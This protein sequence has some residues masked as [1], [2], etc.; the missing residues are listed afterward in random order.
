MV[1][2]E[3]IVKQF[4][5]LVKQPRPN[6][7]EKPLR[8]ATS[9]LKWC[10]SQDID[11]VRFLRYRIE[12]TSHSGHIPS[13]ARLK[14]VKIAETWRQ[15]REGQQY[16]DDNYDKL[17]RKAGSKQ[18]Q[19]VKALRILTRSQE[20]VKHRYTADGRYE[21]CITDDY[22]GGFH[23]HSKYCPLCPANGMCV[24]KLNARHGFNVVALR[25]GRLN[26]LPAEIAA[27][28]VR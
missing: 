26:K 17:K 1:T 14:S 6:F 8:H 10:K 19:G 7:H 5:L 11:P 20:M 24:A 23:P 15:W 16:A 12:N 9:Y 22:S 28:A 13:L 3:E 27:A 2:A 4:Y 18:Q 21:L 25:E